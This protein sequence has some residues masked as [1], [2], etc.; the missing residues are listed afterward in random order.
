[1]RA[2][3][4]PIGLVMAVALLHATAGVA[5]ARAAT[6]ADAPATGIPWEKDFKS[7][8]RRAHESGRPVLVDFW[9]AWCHW[10]HKLDE[11]TYRDP[12][13]VELSRAFVAVKVDT[14]GGIAEGELMAR[15]GVQTL[16]T[17]GFL[18]PSGRLFLRRTA[19]EEPEE[20]RATL[21]QA[22]DLVREVAAFEAALARQAKDPEA[23]AGLGALLADRELYTES[24]D[25][26]RA[27]RKADQRRPVKERKRT[28]RALALGEYARGK[29]ADAAK[30]LAEAL[31]LQP[32]DPEEDAAA[33]QALAALPPR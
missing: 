27:A 30:L 23:L 22:R 2:L 12:A 25:L 1:M 24:L 26:L 32:A 19:Y 14:E 29:P 21:S 20:F 3:L 15:Y 9:A 13:V 6:P 8:A 16:P 7:A 18:S 4:R 31:A 10:C 28:R 33:R 17:I 5:P 11:T